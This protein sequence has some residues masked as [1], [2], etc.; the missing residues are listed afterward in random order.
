M[1]EGGPIT[2]LLEVTRRAVID[3]NTRMVR[4]GAQMASERAEVGRFVPP[5]YPPF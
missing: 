4:G 1:T 5:P 3:G 2:G